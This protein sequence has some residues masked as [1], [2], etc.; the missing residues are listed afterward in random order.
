MRLTPPASWRVIGTCALA[1]AAA[2]AIAGAPAMASAAPAAHAPAAAVPAGFKASA[3]TWI[4]PS[5]GWVLGAAMCGKSNCA[6]SQVIGTTDGGKTWSLTGTV[7][8]SIPKLG[9]GT[10]GITEIR[11]ATSQVGWI[12]A[13]G[14]FRTTNGGKTWAAQPIPGGGKQ[15]LDL[16]VTPTAAYAIV[17]PCAYQTG[18]CSGGHLPLT[19][20]RTSLTGT[21]W[22]RI[23]LPNRLHFNVAANVAAYG[24]TVYLINPRVEQG[25]HT[26]F[27]ASTDGGAHFSARPNPCT[28]QEEYSL[29]QAAPYSATKVGLLCDGNPG[30]GK[31]VKSVYLSRD[32]GRTDTYAGTMTGKG[33]FGIQAQ[34]TVS[35]SGN[36]AVQAWS[37]GS[38]ILIN[39][40]KTGT[41]WHQIIGSGDGGAGFN[42]ITYV[43]KKVAWVVYGPASMFADYGLLY[44]TTDAGRK[45]VRVNF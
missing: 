14:L 21:T 41:T 36:L 26:E 43:S 45:W 29:I 40:T 23:K 16:A 44:R 24:S 15:V 39:D 7:N 18:F 32:T 10:S 27:F 11:M 33:L 25:L 30:F 38:F 2:F 13:P 42:D 5:K 1:S 34:L 3:M 28:V 31:A 35:P 9:L 19:A 6:H 17:S 20:W 37:I 4:G 12:F 8:A 22:T